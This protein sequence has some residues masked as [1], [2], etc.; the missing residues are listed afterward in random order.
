MQISESTPDHE[1]VQKAMEMTGKTCRYAQT[2]SSGQTTDA[3]ET[4]MCLARGLLR[5]IEVNEQ[6][7]QQQQQQQHKRHHLTMQYI[8]QEYR[9]WSRSQP[10]EKGKL[11]SS[12]DKGEDVEKI[13]QNAYQENKHVQSEMDELGVTTNGS[14]VRVMPLIVYAL[15]LPPD[16]TFNLIRLE[17]SLTH[18]SY[19]VYYAVTAYALTAQYLIRF[20]SQCGRHR[21]AIKFAQEFLQMQHRIADDPQKHTRAI[22]EIERWIGDA[23][24]IAKS[25]ESNSPRST[26]SKVWSKDR[27][28]LK[29]A[30]SKL[31]PT[32]L[33]ISLQLAFY[34]LYIANSFQQAIED[35]L[36][37]GGAANS[38]CCVV[39]G[40]MG[41]FHGVDHFR[42]F[43]AKIDNWKPSQGVTTAANRA[44]YQA[45]HYADYLPLLLKF[46]LHPR[47]YAVD[48]NFYS[49]DKTFAEF[50][51]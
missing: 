20:P 44:P 25:S 24:S 32:H 3:S 16:K 36:S 39:G 33:K 9:V 8:V 2:M 45:K 6:Q 17:S 11:M 13:R 40:L 10:L 14:L 18:A 22:S 38:N 43:K 21:H 50:I 30:H 34:H 12:I 47:D 15:R 19:V 42:T 23:I 4:A 5:M 27:A 31:V 49:C 48:D 28:K 35:T 29:T 51:M 7:Q 1:I 26:R 46:A 37:F 41:A